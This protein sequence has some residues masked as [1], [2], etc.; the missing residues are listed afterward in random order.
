MPA[1]TGPAPVLDAP[2]GGSLPPVDKL[3]AGEGLP[4]GNRG[5]R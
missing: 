5:A 2:T 4:Q 1:T 3:D